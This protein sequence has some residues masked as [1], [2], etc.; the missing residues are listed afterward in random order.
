MWAADRMGVSHSA[1]SQQVGMRDTRLSAPLF[2][3]KGKGLWLTGTRREIVGMSKS[4]DL[5][6][7]PI[8]EMPKTFATDIAPARDKAH[9]P[10]VHSFVDVAT[11][12]A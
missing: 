10:L 6:S 5:V 3:G 12:M 4:T 8:R 2:P 9:L 7:H 11:H 1:V